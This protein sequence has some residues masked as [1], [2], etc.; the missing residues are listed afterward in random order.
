MILFEPYKNARVNTQQATSPQKHRQ[1]RTERG[2][3]LMSAHHSIKDKIHTY[4]QIT[5]THDEG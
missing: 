4:N 2:C 3:G 1:M 5:K